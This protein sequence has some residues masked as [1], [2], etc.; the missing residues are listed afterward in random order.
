MLARSP[1]RKRAT[2]YLAACGATAITVIDRDGV[3]V[4]IVGLTAKGI[5]AG[6]WWI[7]AQDAQRVASA[8]RRFVGEGA[9]V[10]EVVQAVTRSAGSIGASLTPDDIAIARAAVSMMTLDAMIEEMGRDGTLREFNR[11]YKAGR[12]AAAAEGRGYMNY[13]HARARLKKALIPGLQ[14]GRPIPGLF[15]EVFR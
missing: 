12:A 6:R 10:S 9:D 15:A 11:R 4:V 8:A 5:V 1:N 14:S 2:E 7:A 3:G 13:S